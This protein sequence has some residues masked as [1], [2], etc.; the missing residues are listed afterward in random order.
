MARTTGLIET[1]SSLLR[2]AATEIVLPH[3]GSLQA[4]EIRHET[5]NEVVTIV[6]HKVESFLASQLAELLPGSVVLGEEAAKRQPSLRDL[7]DGTSL[8]WL[9][10]PLD[11]TGNFVAGIPCFSIMATLVERGQTTMS[12]M[13]DPLT[14]VLAACEWG[15]GAFVGEHR[16]HAPSRLPDASQL[17]GAILKRFLP[18]DLRL[19]VESREALFGQ[20]LPGMKCAG[21]EYPALAT[22]EEDFALFWRTEPWDHAPGAL[23]LE[24]AGG[25][26]AR[27][28]GQAYRPADPGQGLLAAGSEEIWNTAHAALGLP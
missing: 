7:L 19:H 11:G 10:D 12:W 20:V 9:L 27:L 4:S 14:N 15:A 1:V 18:P 22:G 2:S 24:E 5:G 17:R 21:H 8:V 3:F 26:V 13:L 6:D 25:H 16:I 23:F 28:D